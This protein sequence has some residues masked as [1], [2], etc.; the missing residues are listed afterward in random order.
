MSKFIN[1]LDLYNKIK[2][3]NNEYNLIDNNED[4]KLNIKEFILKILNNNTYNENYNNLN[5]ILDNYYEFISSNNI[6][7]FNIKEH[8]KNQEYIVDITNKKIDEYNEL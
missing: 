8:L 1:T 2:E 4:N 5:N 6:F 7:N 3:I